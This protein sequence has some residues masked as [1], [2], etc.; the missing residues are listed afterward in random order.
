MKRKHYDHG[1]HMY[2]RDGWYWAYVDGRRVSLKSKD[3]DEAIEAYNRLAGGTD[4]RKKPITFDDAVKQYK[5]S[6][7]FKNLAAETQKRHAWCFEKHLVPHFKIRHV[8]KIR[9]PDI[10][11][12]IEARQKQGAASNTILKD[13]TAL[14]A[15][16]EWCREKGHIDYN[17]ARGV[18]KP[19]KRDVV[20]PYHTPTEDEINK[21]LNEIHSSV[22][23]FFLALSNTGARQNELST[24]DVGDFDPDLGTVRIIRKGGAEDVLYLNDI[25]KNRIT[26][27]LLKRA[28]KRD[29]LPDEPLFLNRYKKRLKD[30]NSSIASAC[31]RAKVPHMSHHSLRHG[32][33][34]ICFDKYGMQPTDVAN[35]LGN[36]LEVCMEIYV[37]WQ[38]R[39]KKELARTVQ[40]GCKT[41]FV[42]N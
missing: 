15:C 27:D 34:T 9:P 26:D 28:E 4:L 7:R 31:K 25:V 24:A 42:Q 5:E 39:K 13:T 29:V 30:I 11:T 1:N 6:E 32:Y 14:S 3:Q 16:F 8:K 2:K 23:T 36:S 38:N 10:Y 21:V 37:K 17:F 12:Y 41:G 18:K 33:A 40:V 20:R 35:L 22:E 19:S